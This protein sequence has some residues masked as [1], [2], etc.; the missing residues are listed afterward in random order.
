[1]Q[2][3]T[4]KVGFKLKFPEALPDTIGAIRRVVAE[5]FPLLDPTGVND[6][7]LDHVAPTEVFGWRYNR[8]RQ[9]RLEG[10]RDKIAHMLSE[11]GGDLSLS[12]D[13]HSH[14]TEV[15]RW[16]SL[17]RLMARVMIR[18]EKARLPQIPGIFPSQPQAGHISDL[19]ERFRNI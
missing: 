11:S 1:M 4:A 8:I 19:R 10:I 16:I 6:E 7:R 13:T 18:N 2:H 9:E 14:R 15:A 5:V 17:L 3:A 12:P